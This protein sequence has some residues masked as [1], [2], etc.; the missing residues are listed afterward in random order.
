LLGPAS[1]SLLAD[2]HLVELEYC[3]SAESWIRTL[4]PTIGDNLFALIGGTGEVW[5]RAKDQPGGMKLRVTHPGLSRKRLWL[6]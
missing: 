3:E 2:K 1:G 5:I 6:A 4:T